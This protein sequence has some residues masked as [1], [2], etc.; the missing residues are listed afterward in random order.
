MPR[1]QAVF[2]ANDMTAVG[3]LAA[4]TAAG[5]RVPEDIALGGFDDVP[6]ARYVTPALTTIRVPIVELGIAATHA[7]V[8]RIENGPQQEAA[9]PPGAFTPS[10]LP[11]ELLT[12]RST[13]QPT[14]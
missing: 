9:S 6:I 2:A 12:R 11:V 10:V 5:L 4:L 14:G 1:P 8:K 3:V 7:L 13:A